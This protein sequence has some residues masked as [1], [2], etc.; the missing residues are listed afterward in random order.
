MKATDC[1]LAMLCCNFVTL[2]VCNNNDPCEPLMVINRLSVALIVAAKVH[3]VLHYWVGAI[4]NHHK[5]VIK[6]RLPLVED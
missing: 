6:T 1:I 5:M 2:L 3:S 4:M